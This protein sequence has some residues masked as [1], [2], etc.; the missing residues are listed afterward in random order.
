MLLIFYFYQRQKIVKVFYVGCG[1][2]SF[3]QFLNAFINLSMGDAVLEK[4]TLIFRLS[5]CDYFCT[6]NSNKHYIR[7]SH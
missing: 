7:Y 2:S 5:Q 3:P 1:H 6:I 4:K